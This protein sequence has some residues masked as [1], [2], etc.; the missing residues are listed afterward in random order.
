MSVAHLREREKWNHK[1][2]R[3]VEERWKRSCQKVL[4]ESVSEQ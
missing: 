4:F 3:Y 1:K 2:S